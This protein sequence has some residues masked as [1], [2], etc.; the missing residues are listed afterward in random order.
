MLT[1]VKR[2]AQAVR[3]HVIVGVFLLG[4][5]ASV[6]ILAAGVLLGV[7]GRRKRR[8]PHGRLQHEHR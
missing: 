2:W 7:I 1:R 8:S 5:A 6:F 4:V 3:E